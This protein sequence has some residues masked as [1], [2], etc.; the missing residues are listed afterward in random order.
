MMTDER[1]IQFLRAEIARYKKYEGEYYEDSPKYRYYKTRVKTFRIILRRFEG[2][3][4]DLFL[5][6]KENMKEKK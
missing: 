3:K 5:C 1:I 6:C 2:L 4:D